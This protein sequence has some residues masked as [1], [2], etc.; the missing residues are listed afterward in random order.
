MTYDDVLTC[1][2]DV[3]RPQQT[4]DI[5]RDMLVEAKRKHPEAECLVGSIFNLPGGFKTA[6]CTRLLS[7]LQPDELVLA[8]A[9]LDQAADTLVFTFNAGVDGDNRGTP[10]YTHS[11]E[12]LQGLVGDRTWEQHYIPGRPDRYGRRHLA[13]RAERR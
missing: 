7:W 13:V 2:A 9:Q 8:M 1:F 12:T 4:I 3:P 11:V 10:S 6:V 5:S